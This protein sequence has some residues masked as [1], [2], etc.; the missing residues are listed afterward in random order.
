MNDWKMTADNQVKRSF[1]EHRTTEE[2]PNMVK[3]AL[4]DLLSLPAI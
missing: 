3:R 1:K 2:Y 4:H